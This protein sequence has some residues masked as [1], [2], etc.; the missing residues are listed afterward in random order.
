MKDS[1]DSPS[2]RRYHGAGL[3]VLAASVYLLGGPLTASWGP[4]PQI[5]IGLVV[6][7]ALLAAQILISPALLSYG[8]MLDLRRRGRGWFARG[9][10]DHRLVR[11]HQQARWLDL[12]LPFCVTLWFYTAAWLLLRSSALWLGTGS[13]R[14]GAA[15]A[16]VAV[17]LPLAALLAPG[18]L[19]RVGG[20]RPAAL[21]D[22]LIQ[23]AV[24]LLRPVL[25]PAAWLGERW[26]LP[27][28]DA[29]PDD[30]L[31][32][33]ELADVIEVGSHQG[34]L[35][36]SQSQ[37]LRRELDFAR[38][39]AA[40]IMVPR[41]TVQYL[42]I[43]LTLAEAKERAVQSPF[44]R[45]PVQEGSV[46]HVVAVLHAKQLLRF[47]TGQAPDNLRELLALTRPRPPLH[48]RFDQPLEDVLEALRRNKASLAVVDDAY[49]GVAGIVTV[50]D[51]VEEIVG[52]IVDESD[53]E[54]A[55]E[56][57]TCSGRRLLGEL[58]E[59]G[60]ELPGDPEEPLAEF[61]AAQLGEEPQ[62]GQIWSSA[63]I[64]LVVEATDA[65]GTIE[66]VR[67]EHDLP[68]RGAEGE[69]RGAH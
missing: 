31:P 49:G 55:R 12:V 60:I 32:E 10:D 66:V 14:F 57:V 20:D 5:V 21:A 45:F 67:A 40:D 26:L 11:L 42:D 41:V 56:T 33:E 24:W 59:I 43:N 48:V 29:S 39:T 54:A 9:A 25:R 17:L 61:L 51:V 36:I 34:D 44:S 13:W 23:G 35:T 63:G 28:P 19:V 46:D 47:A 16:A 53:T 37:L 15:I 58:A 3:V 64:R 38:K 8:L 65:A 18:W 6:A 30:G 2:P 68:G 22:S 62:V 7:A 1:A 69:R 4:R 52:E 50:E 27:E